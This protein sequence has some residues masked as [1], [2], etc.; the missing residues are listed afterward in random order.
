MGNWFG[1]LNLGLKYAIVL[2]ALIFLVFIAGF[3]KLFYVR[4]KTRKIMAEAKAKAANE[5]GKIEQIAL[6]QREEGEGDLFGIRALERGFYGGVAQSRPTTPTPASMSAS[7]LVQSGN[8]PFGQG[9]A[10][11]SVITI[12]VGNPKGPAQLPP[13]KVAVDM[14]LNVP[15]SP[16]HPRSPESPSFPRSPS[17]L[18]R[19]S[20][21]QL[22]SDIPSS[23]LGLNN[24]SSSNGGPKIQ[25]NMTPI[26]KVK[27]PTRGMTIFSDAGSVVDED[28]PPSS[29]AGTN[30]SRPPPP[31]PPRPQIKIDGPIDDEPEREVSVATM[32]GAGAG[33]GAGSSSSGGAGAGAGVGA[34]DREGNGSGMMMLGV[35]NGDYNNRVSSGSL[36][37][38]YDSYYDGKNRDSGSST[39]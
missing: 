13:S 5:E 1:D 11:S 15:D 33:V 27:E 36:S 21:P 12:D 24:Y 2:G 35:D 37:D 9:S 23:G 16:K 38:V 7:T 32:R 10:T 14:Q 20:S 4:Q 25:S 29:P 22:E 31:S 17:P 34:E 6:N 30:F 26:R 8:I 39:A 19:G 28:S 3:M 18:S